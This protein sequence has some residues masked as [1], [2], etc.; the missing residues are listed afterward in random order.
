MPLLD[1]IK[2]GTEIGKHPGQKYIWQACQ[3]CGK[4][5]W[6][7]FIKGQP[8]N[9]L[10][11]SCGKRGNRCYSWKGGRNLR[12]D[13]YV[14]V[15]IPSDDFFFPM[16][17]HYNY[18]LEHRLVMARHLKRRL[19]S[20]EIVHHKNGIRDDNRIENLELLKSQATHSVSI[21]IQ[22]RISKM[23]KEIEILKKRVTLL[24]AENVLLKSEHSL[25]A[26]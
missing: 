17:V 25:L 8:I 1:E 16:A 19:L 18:V 14:E 20:W 26:H 9:K 23:Q 10:C 13:G 5:R 3:D 22:K 4:E 24:E 7:S 12:P 21:N 11:R 6:V 15:W 2:K